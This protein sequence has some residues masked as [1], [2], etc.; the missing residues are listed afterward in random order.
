MHSTTADRGEIAKCGN[1]SAYSTK[2]NLH[3]KSCLKISFPR[4]I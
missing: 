1:G 2:F 4:V 3:S